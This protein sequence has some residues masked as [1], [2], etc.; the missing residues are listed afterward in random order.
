MN[1]RRGEFHLNGRMS[2]ER[3]IFLL[4]LFTGLACFAA[5]EAVSFFGLVRAGGSDGHGEDRAGG[6]AHGYVR[7]DLRVGG[8]IAVTAAKDGPWEKRVVG[9]GCGE[10]AAKELPEVR[11][12]CPGN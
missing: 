4:L 5:F 11:T 9:V 1:S 12:T 7:H 3:R 2:I 8:R 6:V 10:R